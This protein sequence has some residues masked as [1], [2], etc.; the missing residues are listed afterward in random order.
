MDNNYVRQSIYVVFNGR[1]ILECVFDV[2]YMCSEVNI[3]CKSIV[4]FALN[5]Q[6]MSSMNVTMCILRST[7]ECVSQWW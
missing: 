2:Q 6:C 5:G 3:L 1:H 4:E 7:V